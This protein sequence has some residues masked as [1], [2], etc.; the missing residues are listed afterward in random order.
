MKQYFFPL[1]VSLVLL[2][3]CSLIPSNNSS[4]TTPSAEN[5]QTGNPVARSLRDILSLGTAQK[6]TFQYTED[7][8][9]FQ[10]EM[11]VS[12]NKFKQTNLMTEEEVSTTVYSISDGES[13]YTWN[14]AQPGQGI[15]MSL[16][17]PKTSPGVTS[18][19]NQNFD[20][21]KQVDYDCQPVVVTDADFA[22]P[23]N[24]EFTDFNETM[25]QFQDQIKNLDLDSLKN[26]A[27]SQ[28]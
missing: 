8:N 15:K 18:T 10:G 1:I 17:P 16:T 6:C 23:E 13:L 4:T 19:Q 24:V 20:L 12:G 14:S 27:P 3:G 9:T 11:L 2:S 26:L 7:G 25:N 21:D 5:P 22:L 28:E